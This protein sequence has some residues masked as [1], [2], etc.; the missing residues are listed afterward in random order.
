MTPLSEFITAHC[1]TVTGKIKACIHKETWWAAHQFEPYRALIVERTAFLPDAAT[2]LQRFYHILHN[3]D[4]I[5]ACP[6]CSGPVNWYNAGN[7]YGTYCSQSC[8][9]IASKEQRQ[10]T[11]LQKYGV[12]SPAQ[13]QA[14][15][16]ASKQT[17]LKKH[18]V[19]N[20]AKSTEFKSIRAQQNAALTTEQREQTASRRRDTCVQRFGVESPLQADAVKEKIAATMRSR[21]GVDYPLQSAEI[22]DR[23]RRTNLSKFGREYWT[24]QHIVAEVIEQLKS[25]EWVEAQLATQSIHQLATSSGMSFS[26]LCKIVNKH[27]LMPANY[28]SFHT[29]VLNFICTEL[30]IQGVV[31]N[32]RTTLAGLEIDILI[33]HMKIG[34]ECNGVYWHSETAGR[35]APSYH[36]NK[37]VAA[38]AAG[39]RLLHIFDSEWF[40]VK[41]PQIEAKLRNILHKTIKKAHGRRCDIVP[42]T[43]AQERAFISANHLQGYAASSYCIGLEHN[44]A[45]VAAMSFAKPRY[46][47]KH[48][49]ELLRYCTA[50]DTVVHGG[51]SKLLRHFVKVHE[52]NELISYCDRRWSVGNVYV[53][54]GFALC[55]ESPPAYYYHND[56]RTLQNRVKFQKHK[57]ATLLE[58]Y[59]TELTEWQNM[60][61]NGYDRIW[62]CGCLTYIWKNNK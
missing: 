9:V 21:Y 49:W 25:K 48:A 50:S 41:R 60:Q 47:N 22:R 15:K 29:E 16:E 31:C 35:K 18:G 37:T 12:A 34:I 46:T 11:S 56:G 3:S 10:R 23:Q 6:Q 44:G 30:G 28:S 62:D 13:S 1:L 19:D 61:C 4:S 32:D 40:G 14:V 43:T 24:Q 5:P 52:V 8:G 27:G 33:P 59:S 36:L 38:T 58:T 39:I 17:N 26:Q 57:L 53:T 2:L 54:N 42:L 51:F 55:G 45:I 20:F 7:R